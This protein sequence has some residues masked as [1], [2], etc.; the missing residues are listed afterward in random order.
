H[1]GFT[2][3]QELV[4]SD[5]QGFFVY[6]LKDKKVFKQ[7]FQ[8]GELLK[9]GLIEIKSGLSK[10]DLLITSNPNL[11]HDGQAVETS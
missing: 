7:Y 11:L 3:S 8:A 10:G 5:S 6:L 2:V 4:Q 9:S 1:I